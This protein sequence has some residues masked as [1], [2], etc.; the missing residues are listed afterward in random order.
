M[1]TVTPNYGLKKP[2][3]TENFNV[4]DQNG[5]MDL[6][7]LAIKANGDA[8]V[9]VAKDYVRSPA[10]GV[11]TGL[12]NAYTFSAMPATILIDGMAVYLDNIVAA[13]TGAS[14]L[15]WSGLGAK[16]I[17]DSKGI[18]LT[19]GKMPLGCIVGMRYNASAASGVG[20]FQ[21]LG[22]GSDVLTGDL[23]AANLLLGKTG[24]SNNPLV[25]IIGTLDLT[26][27]VSANLK[28]GITI[29]GTV[30][31]TEVV[32]T[33]EATLPVA[34]TDMLSGKVGFVNGVK[35]IGTMISKIG[36]A[37]VIIPN[38]GD[39]AIPQG[40]YD[41]VIAS[42]K[43]V[44]TTVT[45][46]SLT[47]YEDFTS[48]VTP[49]HTAVFQIV[50][51]YVCNFSG[52][53]RIAFTFTIQS[54]A[55]PAYARI[56]KNDVAAGILRTITNTTGATYTEDIA[57]VRGDVISIEGRTDFSLTLAF[58]NVKFQIAQANTFISKTL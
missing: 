1:S 14:T 56:F 52:I 5:N 22:E 10:F 30:G 18:A 44:G 17:L 23:V 16:A 15:D 25:K 41:G 54:T 11:A 40:Y 7:D 20:A 19:A 4:L 37:T 27:L 46:G 39:Q 12:V 49:N 31:K 55:N 13:N 43:V 3:G 28:A 47:V 50:K 51:T 57:V 33:T 58:T 8:I 24:Y 42:G 9:N 34:V 36:S 35:R 2:V 48:Q 6:I 26:L 45:A 53:V 32:D 29:N 38:G 21:L